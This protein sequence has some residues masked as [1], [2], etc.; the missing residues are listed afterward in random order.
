MSH[1][2]P[3]TDDCDAAWV[4]A[5]QGGDPAAWDA[6]VQRYQP[7][8]EHMARRF[9]WPSADV[10][11]RCQEA[12]IGWM[13]AVRRFD[14]ARGIPFQAFA[15]QCMSRI[16]ITRLQEAN[17]LQRKAP[18]HVLSWEALDADP[19]GVRHRFDD[20][21]DIVLARET[22]ELLTRQCTPLE[23]AVL[24]RWMQGFPYEEIADALGC[25][26]KRVDNALQ[27]IRKKFA[28]VRPVPS[29]R[30]ERKSS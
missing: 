23:W 29:Y 12:W 8:V 22:L 11:D 24:T 2:Y 7:V 28:R 13:D 20:P 4:R 1:P 16:L 30:P 21:V 25:S 10:A 3:N 14:S 18:G 15:A 6:L 26:R 9:Y 5:A 27:R 19:P 17:R